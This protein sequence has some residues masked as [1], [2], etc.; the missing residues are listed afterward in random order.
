MNRRF[1]IGT[2]VGSKGETL[3]HEPAGI[4]DEL[5]KA[6]AP[7]FAWQSIDKGTAFEL[8]QSCAKRWK[9]DIPRPSIHLIVAIIMRAIDS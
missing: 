8:I 5:A 3:A 1:S 2:I 7:V 6:W 4:G 9:W